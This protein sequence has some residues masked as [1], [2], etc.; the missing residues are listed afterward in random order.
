[1][2]TINNTTPSGIRFQLQTTA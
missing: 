1:M 2:T